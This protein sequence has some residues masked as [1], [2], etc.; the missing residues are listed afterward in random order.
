M[1]ITTL[2]PEF[3]W[4]VGVV[5]LELKRQ[6]SLKKNNLDSREKLFF[7]ACHLTFLFWGEVIWFL[8]L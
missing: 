2:F 1:Q 6:I 4:M 8:I 7:Q 3:I 5:T